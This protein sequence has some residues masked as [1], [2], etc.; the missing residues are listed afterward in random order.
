[1]IPRN[2]EELTYIEI[3]GNDSCVS[4][5]RIQEALDKRTS[6]IIYCIENGKLCGI[7]SVGDIFRGN[8]KKEIE[9]NKEFTY[10][11]DWNVIKAKQ[12]FADYRNIHKIPVLDKAGRLLGDY[13]RWDDIRFLKRNKEKY[14]HLVNAALNEKKYNILRSLK[15]YKEQNYASLL[16]QLDEKTDIIVVS[17]TCARIEKLEIYE[18]MKSVFN[19][20]DV[21]YLECSKRKVVDY[22]DKNNIILFVDEDELKGTEGIFGQTFSGTA[23]ELITY[24]SL[25]AKGEKAFNDTIVDEFAVEEALEQLQRAGVQCYTVSCRENINGYLHKYSGEQAI[26]LKN[27]PEEKREEIC[28]ETAESFFCE[29][30]TEEYWKKIVSMPFAVQ[31]LNGVNRLKDVNSEYLNV[32]NGERRTCSQPEQFDRTIYFYGPCIIMGTLVEDQYTIESFLQRLLIEQ[33]Y[34]CRV[35]NLGC[36]SG[37]IDCGRIMETKYREGDIV[38]VYSY[39]KVFKNIADINIADVAEM[40]D[41]PIEW[42]TD[43]LIHC[44]HKANRVYADYIFGKIEEKIKIP[45]RDDASSVIADRKKYV[46]HI[47]IDKYFSEF[48]PEKYK[49]IGAIVMNCNPFTLGHRYLIE[50]AYK[51]VDFLIIFV[52]EEDKSVFSFEERFEMVVEGTKDLK[53]IMVV[54][55]GNFIL[56]QTT[57]PEYFIKVADEDIIR[58]VDYDIT[59]FS[60][61]ICSWL[62]VRYRFVGNEPNDLVTRTY[63]DAMKR[64]LPAN[65]IEVV[66]ISRIGKNDEYIS[67]SLVRK[68]FENNALEK[69][70]ELL[71][72]TTRTMLT[73]IGKSAL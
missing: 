24:R 27:V 63:N 48:N 30:Y 39:D 70:W 9:I 26:R 50:E 38:I 15:R 2:F 61:C 32:I 17:P 49:N 28:E 23:A 67:A 8:G 55:S 60:D 41:I 65:G 37:P 25:L 10:L 64:I 72:M 33:G 19:R 16:A 1:M 13:S 73:G 51:K 12:I 45:V 47:Y 59:L 29:L 71:P 36:W 35:V 31:C 7:I 62:N 42:S 66:E 22:I 43:R 46:K 54:P 11:V 40:N 58:N 34:N 14:Y 52:V 69:A 3:D 6:E 21:N 4:M 68:Y 20:M 5:E 18:Q 53:Q 56:S 44:N 57:F